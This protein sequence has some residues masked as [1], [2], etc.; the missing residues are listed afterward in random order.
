MSPFPLAGVLAPILG[1]GNPLDETIWADSDNLVSGWED[2]GGATT[3][4]YQSVDSDSDA[5]WVELTTANRIP[6]TATCG[7]LEVS[8]TL[9]FNLQDPSGKPTPNQTVEVRCKMEYVVLLA[10]N[11]SESHTV[12]I[13]LR[14]G[15][16]SRAVDT[17]NVLTTTPTEFSLFLNTT[18]INSVSDWNNLNVSLEFTS[19]SGDTIPNSGEF[20]LICYR[21]RL[22]FAP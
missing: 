9:R 5:D 4:L 18:Q 1:S 8:R 20:D 17:N 13:R 3:N 14:E 10:G 16:T 11:G 2:E 22:I 6:D 7:G 12:D 19:C 21:C 15:T